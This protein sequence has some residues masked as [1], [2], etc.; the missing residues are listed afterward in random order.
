MSMIPALCGAIIGGLFTLLGSKLA[1][2]LQAKEKEKH[3][4]EI[5]YRFIQS[6]YTEIDATYQRYS[7]LS[8]SIKKNTEILNS[9]MRIEEDYFTIYHNNAAYIGLIKNDEL[10]SAIINFYI[11]AKGLIDSIRTNNHLLDEFEKASPQNQ[12]DIYQQLYLYLKSMKKEDL[13]IQSSYKKI[14]NLRKITHT[15]KPSI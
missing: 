5:E 14:S 10:R 15:K 4:D 11:Q 12:A 3:Q 9:S 7:A 1:A 2:E 8:N 6:I 13:N